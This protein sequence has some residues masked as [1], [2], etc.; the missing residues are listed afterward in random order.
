MLQ[1]RNRINVKNLELGDY[2]NNKNINNYV[3]F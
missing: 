3:K 1:Y 2:N